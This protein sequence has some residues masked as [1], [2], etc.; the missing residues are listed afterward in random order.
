MNIYQLLLYAIKSL[1]RHK[2]RS[3]LT[4]LGII[5]GIVAIIA[6]MSIGEGAKYQVR[7]RI[8]SL[9]SN[10]VI[11]LGA[12]PKHLTTQRGAVNL[13]LKEKD[14]EAI[15]T[16]CDDIAFA[17]PGVHT[18]FKVVYKGNNWQ[19]SVAGVNEDYLKIRNW[20]LVEGNFFTKH[21]VKANKKVAII[22]QTVVKEIFGKIDP[23]GK[24]IRIKNIP[25]T[26]IGTL[27][28]RGKLPDGRDEDDII[29]MP[30]TSI[31]K[32]L[33]GIR[34]NRFAA[35]ILSIKEKER[36]SFAANEIRAILRQQHNLAPKDEDD[37][38]IFTQDEISQASEAASQILNILLLIIASISLIVGGIGIM[39]IMLVTVKER[40]REIG[41]R[42]AIGATTQAILNQ[43]ILEAIVICLLGGILGMF[44]GIGISTAVGFFLE[45]PIFISGQA[46]TISLVSS[47]FIGLFFGFY[48][49]R[50]AA[51]LNPVDALMSE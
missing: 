50:K 10:F 33:M 19:P 36:M 4:T 29:F 37:F 6:V 23:I 16:E 47:I 48:P 8:E 49:A 45:W 31:Q 5:V 22:G 42:M 14:F 40:T 38:T 13:T 39:N 11:V 7:K 44:F 12:T 17:S 3:L 28:G 15:M 9:G 46:I 21:D 43:F 25:F 2:L 1:N 41:I 18:T 27:E 51:Q 24:R 20:D 34:V 30:I 35:I 32:R 26:V